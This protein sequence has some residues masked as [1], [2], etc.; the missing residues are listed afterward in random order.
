MH[1]KMILTFVPCAMPLKFVREK[2]LAELNNFNPLST[3]V[4]NLRTPLITHNEET[5]N[6][7]G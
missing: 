5:I 7:L 4:A 2:R 6:K 3:S 1:K